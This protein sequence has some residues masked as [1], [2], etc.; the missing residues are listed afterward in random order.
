MFVFLS[1][2]YEQFG[3]VLISLSSPICVGFTIRR[4]RLEDFN[5]GRRTGLCSECLSA[6]GSDKVDILLCCRIRAGRIIDS[7]AHSL[8]FR[9]A[10]MYAFLGSRSIDYLKSRGYPVRWFQYECMSKKSCL[11]SYCESL[12]KTSWTYF[13]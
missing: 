7:T 4:V 10:D 12:N 13:S 1:L 2:F 9:P 8:W 6:S 11:F 5:K 3:L